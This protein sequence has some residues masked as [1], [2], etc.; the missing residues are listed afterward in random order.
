LPCPQL[1][2]GRVY[3]LTRAVKVPVAAVSQGKYTIL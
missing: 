2:Q 3:G 1:T